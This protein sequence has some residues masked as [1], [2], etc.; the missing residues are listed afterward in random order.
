MDSTGSTSESAGAD[1]LSTSPSASSMRAGR[2]ESESSENQPKFII[3]GGSGSPPKVVTMDEIM[4]VVKNIEDMTLA[5]EIAINPDFKL[6][7]YEPPDNSIEK[8]VKE[9]MT[10]AY[11]D[12]LR[13]QLGRTPPSFDHAISLLGEIK[14][15]LKDVISQKNRKAL[16]Q[17]YE[18]LDEKVIRQQAEQSVLNFRAYANFVIDI[19]A[20]SCAPI[21]DQQI[22]DLS[23]VEDVVDTFKGIMEMLSIMKLDMANTLLSI[24]RNDVVTNSIEYEK[25]KFKEYLNYYKDGFPATEAWLKR[26]RPTP[27]ATNGNA[28]ATSTSPVTPDSTILNAYVELMD[29]NCIAEFP[30]LLKM[31]QERLIILQQKA[32]RLCTCASAL[33]V[34]S[35][36][37]V[38]AQNQEFKTKLA[39]ELEII[40]ENINTEKDLDDAMQSVWLHILT[41]MK[42]LLIELHQP[43]LDEA[44]E[45]TI[46]HH[47]L[48]IGSK[49]SPV[50]LLLTKRLMNYLKLILRTKVSPPAPPGFTDFPDEIESIAT[51]FKRLTTYNYSVYSEFYREML[52]STESS[53]TTS[54]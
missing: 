2:T 41:V 24:A 47:I 51:A 7:R 43:A 42:Q 9:V 5:H 8:K 38:I 44:S 30:E 19:M 45:N 33:A 13:E 40:L 50:R 16:E 35:G 11:W 34:A 18:V 20:K 39:R 31:D 23:K 25:K 48:Q 17:I 14:D 1:G 28:D 46:K 12:V 27:V 21:R 37:P 15:W 36:V 22:E 54:D 3:P 53:E 52:A 10:K 29:H 26:N 49:D 32:L 6:L 4:G